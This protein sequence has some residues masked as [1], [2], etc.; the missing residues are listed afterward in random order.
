MASSSPN[1]PAYQ[2]YPRGTTSTG[3]GARVRQAGAATAAQ[4]TIAHI[5]GQSLRIVLTTQP[6]VSGNSN[7]RAGVKNR[8]RA[9]DRPHWIEMRAAAQLRPGA[10]YKT[11]RV[12]DHSGLLTS[13]RTW[14]VSWLFL[15]ALS[16][17]E[18][19]TV[20][21]SPLPTNGIG[22]VQ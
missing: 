10:R 9:A 4:Q 8:C 22:V 15:Q 13:A 16:D 20:S 3:S 5:A 12:Y 2:L 17:T 21:L 7:I 19:L 18:Q 14:N 6:D 11:G 1:G